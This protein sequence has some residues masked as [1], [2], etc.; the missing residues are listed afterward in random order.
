VLL[1]AANAGQGAGVVDAA[2][3]EAFLAA[4]KTRRWNREK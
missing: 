4:A 3:D 2:D 1:K